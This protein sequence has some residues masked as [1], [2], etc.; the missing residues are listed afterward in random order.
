MAFYI[1]NSAQRVR[2]EYEYGMRESIYCVPSHQL[3]CI[4]DS[5]RMRLSEAD[6]IGIGMGNICV[7]SNDM[8]AHSKWVMVYW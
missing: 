6:R 7:L 1:F 5:E 2:G 8:T 3:H 4:S